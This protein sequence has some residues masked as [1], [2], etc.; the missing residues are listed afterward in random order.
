[1]TDGY[2]IGRAAASLD[3]SY[4]FYFG[5]RNAMNITD[6]LRA[7]A[8]AAESPVEAAYI[9]LIKSCSRLQ[10]AAKDAAFPDMD[11]LNRESPAYL[12][13]SVNDDAHEILDLAHELITAL[14]N[15]P[16]NT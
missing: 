4:E 5:K 6:A 10:R 14:K 12:A 7:N 3:A 16:P 15:N 11:P 1:M 9:K 2:A 13:N 8:N